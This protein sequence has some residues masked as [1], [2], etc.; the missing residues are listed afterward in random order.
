MDSKKE[1]TD[2]PGSRII[3]VNLNRVAEG[4]RVVEDVCRYMTCLPNQQQELKT[5]RHGIRRIA[6]Q[7][8]FIAVRDAANDTG[9]NSQGSLE[10]RRSSIADIVQANCKR[11]QEGYRSLEELFKLDNEAVARKMKAGRYQAYTIEQVLL[12]ALNRKKLAPG[13][14]LVLTEPAAGYETITEMAVKAGIAAVQL[15]YKGD[16]DRLHLQLAHA[17][18][19]ITKDSKTLFIVNDR[20][21]IGLMSD[22]D[23]IH[24][25][26]E[27]IPA[28]EI[29][30]IIGPDMLL[31][32]ST[33]N[34]EQ[35]EQANAEPVD[36]IGFG[37]LYRTTSKEKPDPVVGPDML[38]QAGRISKHPIV[39][40][41]GL[42]LDRIQQLDLQACQNVA[43]IRAVT[44]AADPLAAMKTIHE[45]A[46]SG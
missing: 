4:L 12:A 46:S 29:R 25:G 9:F 10:Y 22:A 36:Y 20:P 32:L 44:G 14:Y 28:S 31:G 38:Q 33:H 11:I 39:A 17:M 7:N 43:V 8:R 15:R 3:D 5:L 16:D 1:V 27:D 37:P 40:I 41:G 42:T 2:T 45:T 24:V 13:L 21:D 19:A 30:S 26:Q 18:R 23:G 34:P 35:V 6:G